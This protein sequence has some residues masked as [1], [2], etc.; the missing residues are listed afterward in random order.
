M[1]KYPRPTICDGS[2]PEHLRGK[3]KMTGNYQLTIKCD[4]TNVVIDDFWRLLLVAEK[5]DTW[6]LVAVWSRDSKIFYSGQFFVNM[7]TGEKI[8]IEV[9]ISEKCQIS[10][11][12]NYLIDMVDDH[13]N[14]W[15]VVFDI[16]DLK[17]INIIFREEETRGVVSEYSFDANSDFVTKY[18]YEFYKWRDIVTPDY[19]EMQTVINEALYKGKNKY[20]GDSEMWRAGVQIMCSSTTVIRRVDPSK[21]T[22]MIKQKGERAY[23]YS[24]Y[25]EKVEKYVSEGISMSEAQNRSIEELRPRIADFNKQFE[26]EY[27]SFC[28]INEMTETNKT[29]LDNFSEI[30]KYIRTVY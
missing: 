4:E 14:T 23:D 29:A 1:Y 30:K 5:E 16:R 20:V 24:G 28:T 9:A 17:R 21:I 18:T 3:L 2:L 8:K 7:K 11:D 15:Y 12:S 25:E 19:I 27:G 13:A 26:T 10:S 6:V 22:P